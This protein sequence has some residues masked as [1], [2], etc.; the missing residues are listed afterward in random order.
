MSR[1]MFVEGYRGE[2]PEDYEARNDAAVDML[3]PKTP[4]VVDT[5]DEPDALGC[6]VVDLVKLDPGVRFLRIYCQ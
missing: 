5:D 4:A 2:I 3:H 6:V 1:A